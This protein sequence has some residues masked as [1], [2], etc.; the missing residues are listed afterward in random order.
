M[1]NKIE[2]HEELKN[3]A[4][5]QSLVSLAVEGNPV[6]D[7]A[8][9]DLFVVFHLPGLQQYEGSPIS[10]GTRQKAMRKFEKAKADV[11]VVRENLVNYRKQLSDLQ[12]ERQDLAEQQQ[13]LAHQLA[14]LETELLEAK[15]QTQQST[16][17][18]RSI[19]QMMAS[20]SMDQMRMKKVQM[21]EMLMK[22]E[23]LRQTSQNLQQSIKRSR[24]QISTKETTLSLTRKKMRSSSLVDPDPSLADKETALLKELKAERGLLDQTEK[25]YDDVLV[26]L[27]LTMDAIDALELAV[28]I[29]KNFGVAT[30]SAEVARNAFVSV[31]TIAAYIS[32]NKKPTA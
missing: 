16:E 20:S 10:T 22:A 11:Y 30:P 4:S 31:K 25:K 5:L 32:A 29:E 1:R 18:L 17:E 12:G 21:K 6:C 27:Q 13:L 24:D 8:D 28:A 9:L 2:A 26:E 23:D 15:A 3:L 19:Q 7:L 14:T